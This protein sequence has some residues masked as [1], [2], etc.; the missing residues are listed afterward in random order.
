RGQ[1][2]LDAPVRDEWEL[3]EQFT[4]RVRAFVDQQP[5]RSL[6]YLA[7]KAYAA[8]VKVTPEY[9]PYSGEE[10]FFLPKHLIITA[11]L[12][13]NRIVMW[14]SLA[15]AFLTWRHSVR[16]HGWKSVIGD[17]EA[18]RAVLLLAVSLAYLAP[19]VVAFSTY[20]HIVPLYYF[21][22]AY[23]AMFISRS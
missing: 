8:M 3:N 12:L 14:L 16:R 5:L 17:D 7:I 6:W 23:L 18:F 11:A 22:A 15:A 2:E 13:L 21:Q 1:V 19:F 4:N 10:G 9:R 20:R